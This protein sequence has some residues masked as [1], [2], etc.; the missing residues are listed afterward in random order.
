MPS[1]DPPQSEHARRRLADAPLIRDACDLDLLVFLYRH[2]RTMLTSDNLAALVGYDMRQIGK[3]LDAFV[4]A[5]ILE[6]IQSS[7]HAARMYVLSLQGPS[8]GRLKEVLEMASTRKGRR[9]VLEA[10]KSRDPQIKS[11]AAQRP[12]LVK[13]A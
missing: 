5:G 11:D 3:A 10:L 13:I 12:R 1:N 6:R 4:D 9:K 7:T 2:P 8:G